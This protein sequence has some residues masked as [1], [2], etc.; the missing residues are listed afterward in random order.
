MIY[1]SYLLE[2]N[3]KGADKN[4]FL[5]Y[6]EN[7]GLKNGLDLDLYNFVEDYVKIPLIANGGA[8]SL[9]DITNF[10]DNSSFS[11]V[12][13]GSLFVFFGNRNAVLIN[14]PNKFYLLCQSSFK[15]LALLSSPYPAPVVPP[16][17]L[18]K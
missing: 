4:L 5:F 8:S 2:Q 7:E 14:Y 6:G 13:C 18:P 9:N 15:G 1:K 12:A 10:F 16:G 17:L 3:F 11:A